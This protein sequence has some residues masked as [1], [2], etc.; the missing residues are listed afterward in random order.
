MRNNVTRF[1]YFAEEIL[2]LSVNDVKQFLT[3]R[4]TLYCLGLSDVTLGLLLSKFMTS[5]MDDPQAVEDS[6]GRPLFVLAIQ[7]NFVITNSTGPSKFVCHNCDIVVTVKLYVIK[8]IIWDQIM[9][10]IKFVIGVN[11]K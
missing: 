5:F 9:L 3:L 2:R 8:I 4:H 10:Q 6:S 11:L 7:S 1:F